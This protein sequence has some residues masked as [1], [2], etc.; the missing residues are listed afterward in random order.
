LNE[1]GGAAP[2]KK[3]QDV[4]D[5][6]A[7]HARLAGELPHVPLGLFPTP[8]GRLER[9]GS[10]LGVSDLYIKRDDLSGE[11]Y[12]G[13]KV[14]KLEFLL[15]EAV[16]AGAREV[17][18]FGFAGSNHATAT[19]VYARALGLR[20][21]SLLIPQPAAEYVRRNLLLS[22]E[23]GAELHHYPHAALLGW[24]AAY[25]R[26]R[27][28]RLTGVAPHVIAPGGTTALGN[29]GYVNAAFELKEQVAAGLL[30]EPDVIYVASGTM[31]TVAGLVLGLRAVG[32][33]AR[34]V[35]VRV[36]DEK[37]TSIGRL[38][39]LFGRTARL[40][41]A[42]DPC[43]PLLSLDTSEVNLRHEFY[44]AGY[45]VMTDECRAAVRLTAEA[46]GLKLDRTYTGKAFAALAADAEQGELRGKVALF[47]NTYNSRDFSPLIANTDY[48]RLP[49][50]FHRYFGSNG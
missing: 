23:S 11:V 50:A 6:F 1:S 5:L 15:A 17:M 18:T 34:V 27:H 46:E 21:I 36:V 26:W 35:A 22:F 8:V 40:L 3:G 4:I 49:R 44:G 42:A 13:N 24:G 19:A 45:A 39:R 28:K 2:E 14:R 32:M 25:E 16:G 20:S 41:R 43:F 12:G 10:A 47:W 9:L 31:G 38:V 37:F 48:R 7:R 29:V 33:K 30:P